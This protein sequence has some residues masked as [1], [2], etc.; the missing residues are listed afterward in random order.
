MY[1]LCK[2]KN[3]ILNFLILDFSF[4]TEEVL[5]SIGRRREGDRAVIVFFFGGEKGIH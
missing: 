2:K 4:K 3:T 5:R 1:S